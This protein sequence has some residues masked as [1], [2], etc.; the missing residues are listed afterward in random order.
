MQGLV[1]SSQKSEQYS[2]YSQSDRWYF[3]EYR[4]ETP[5]TTS[6][7]INHSSNN[8]IIPATENIRKAVKTVKAGQ[9]IIL[10]GFLIN[11]KGTYRGQNVWWNTSLSRS[12]TGDNS[13]ELFYVSKVRIGNEVYE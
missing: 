2:T 5:F 12:D 13:C 9:K 7:I 1:T 4:H 11:L 3:F 6:Y 8:H 10:D